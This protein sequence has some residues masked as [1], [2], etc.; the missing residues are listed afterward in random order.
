[1]LNSFQLIFCCVCF[2][3][4]GSC[5]FMF[6]GFNFGTSL[7]CLRWWM[8][9]LNQV[10][11]IYCVVPVPVIYFWNRSSVFIIIEMPNS[12]NLCLEQFIRFCNIDGR[13]FVLS[14][15][16]NTVFLFVLG[17]MVCWGVCFLHGEL[18]W[19]GR[20]EED[21]DSAFTVTDPPWTHRVW[22]H[23]QNFLYTKA[24]MYTKQGCQMHS[25][26]VSS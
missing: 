16:Q 4:I 23:P 10:G 19:C 7:C 1:M 24:V 18:Q 2:R 3:T 6:R 5:W 21:D 25:C 15:L 12:C 9:P 17:G 13:E 8:T 11:L 20:E 14:F 22:L 26:I